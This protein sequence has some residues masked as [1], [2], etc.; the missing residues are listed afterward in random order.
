MFDLAE[1]Q[2]DLLALYVQVG[3]GV[4]RERPLAGPECRAA[5]ILYIKYA[6]ATEEIGP[7][8]RHIPAVEGNRLIGAQTGRSVDRAR[9]H[10]VMFYGRPRALLGCDPLSPN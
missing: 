8:M 4:H 6:D 7:M 3:N 1:E 2:F 10:H 9:R 5:R